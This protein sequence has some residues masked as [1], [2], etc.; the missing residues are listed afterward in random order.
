MIT[1]R[2]AADHQITHTLSFSNLK[3]SLKSV[4]SSIAIV[5]PAQ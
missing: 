4:G 1:D 3:N 2:I 5:N